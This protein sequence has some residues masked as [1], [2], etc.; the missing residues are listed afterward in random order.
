[1]KNQKGGII[2]PY[3]DAARQKETFMDYLESS[4]ISRLNKGSYGLT[5]LSQLVVRPPDGSEWIQKMDYDNNRHYYRNETEKKSQYELPDFILNDLTILPVKNYYKKM[6]PSNEYGNPVYHLVIKLCIISD[7]PGDQPVSADGILNGKLNSVK[8]SDFQNEINIQTD[9]FFKTL[10][11]LEPL[12]PGIVYAD[13]LQNSEDIKDILELLTQNGEREIEESLQNLLNFFKFTPNVGLGIIA[14]ELVSPAKTLFRIVEELKQT[15]R[16]SRSDMVKNIARYGILQLALQTEYSQNDFHR[17]NIMMLDDLNYFNSTLYP[18][19][20]IIID[21]GRAVKIPPTIMEI[22]RNL[23]KEGN[24]IGALQYLCDK[25]FSHE[26]ISDIINAD[27]H[28]GWVCGDYNMWG[29]DYNQYID[30]FVIKYNNKYDADT[31]KKY[32]PKPQP[33]SLNDNILIG[34]LFTQREKGMD[35]SISLMN[36]LHNEY[37]EKYP[38]LPISNQIKN[39]LYNG[40]IGGKKNKKNKHDKKDKKSKKNQKTLRQRK[41][42][43]HKKR[44]TFKARK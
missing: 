29:K 18:Y 42:N 31:V 6:V 9:I 7:Q 28:Y 11:Y 14:M 41:K 12:V 37:P 16:I 33:L 27:S 30:D 15:N 13:I 34:K 23:V 19:R 1:M 36:N 21:F 2:L 39:S 4:D 10:Q 26:M 20:P 44:N 5:L 22:I 43:I 8:G 35:T 38:L 32:I 40:M 17:S 24:Y 3:K 25:S